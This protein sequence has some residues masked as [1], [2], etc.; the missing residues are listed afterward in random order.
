[1]AP[2]PWDACTGHPGG[3]NSGPHFD[4]AWCLEIHPFPKMAA[5]SSAISPV[6]WLKR[7]WPINPESVELFV[8]PLGS[9]CS[10]FPSDHTNT[11][12]KIRGKTKSAKDTRIKWIDKEKDC[13]EMVKKML[14]SAQAQ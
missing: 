7:G 4:Q 8:G 5:T 9:I 1:L 12:E 10:I 14:K 11:M 3:R 2:V 13:A 6:H